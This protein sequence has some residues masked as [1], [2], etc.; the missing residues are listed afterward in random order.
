[1]L[2]TCKM[3][4]G[5]FSYSLGHVIICA[6]NFVSTVDLY[7]VS[8]QWHVNNGRIARTTISNNVEFFAIRILETWT[9]SK[10]IAR[11]R[12]IENVDRR[13]LDRIQAATC[14]RRF[15]GGQNMM[16]VRMTSPTSEH[17]YCTRV[18]ARDHRAILMHF[19]PASIELVFGRMPGNSSH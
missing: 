9:P 18:C 11:C 12:S 14:R 10:L 16:S 3:I 17:S 19:R 2:A 1:M 6:D 8:A 5:P 13:R 4:V 7:L 15:L